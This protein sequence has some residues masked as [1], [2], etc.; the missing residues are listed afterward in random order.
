MCSAVPGFCIGLTCSRCHPPLRLF[1][2]RSLLLPVRAIHAPHFWGTCMG[3]NHGATSELSLEL[4][5]LRI[6]VSGPSD[7]VGEFVLFASTFRSGRVRSPDPS[8]GSFE[9][10]SS[11]PAASN[12][13]FVGLETRDQIASTFPVCLPCL[14]LLGSSVLGLLVAGLELCWT[15]VCTRPAARLR[16]ICVLAVTLWSVP[17]LWIP[18]SSSSPLLPI[19]APL[20]YLVITTPQSLSLPLRVRGQGIHPCRGLQGG[21]HSGLALGF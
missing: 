2:H 6:S 19:G 10:V 20:G 16:L 18:L 14:G 5:G 11:Q 4:A 7:L 17:S 1:H 9:V 21:G 13:A 3:H 8:V 12:S 15:L